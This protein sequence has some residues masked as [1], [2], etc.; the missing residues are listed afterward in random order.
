VIPDAQRRDST[1]L[2]DAVEACE[3]YY[4]SLV[5][6]VYECYSTFNTVVDPRWY[7][8]EAN[9]GSRGK[10][11][12]DALVELGFSPTWTAGVPAGAAAWRVLRSQQPPCLVNDLFS[13]FLGKTILDPD[14]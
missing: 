14:E 12:E 8:T 10:S 7:F 5:S 13:R 2:A 4:T 6:V 1:V 11:F 3:H 9:F